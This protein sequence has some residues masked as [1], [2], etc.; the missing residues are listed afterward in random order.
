MG[1][2]PDA[3]AIILTNAEDPDEVDWLGDEGY[4]LDVSERGIVI[5]AAERAG[6]FYGLQ[7]LLQRVDER[8]AIRCVSIVDR[9]RFRWRGMH[10]DVGRHFFTKEFIKRYLDLLALHKFNMFHWHLT[11]DQGWRIEI[12]GYPRLT[13]IGAWRQ[14]DGERY[15]G[16]YTTSDV[17]EI[18]EIRSFSRRP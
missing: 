6:L 8:G 15:G 17:R 13:E 14:G 4:R 16:F 9:P 2:P 1:V 3:D 7:T 18:V 12:P 10:L 11:E 5:S